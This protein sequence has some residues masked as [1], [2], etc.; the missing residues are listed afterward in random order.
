MMRKIP[1]LIESKN[2]HDTLNV[3][4]NKLQGEVEKQ[5]KDDK[6][7]T[8]EKK[9]CNTEILT[10]NDIPKEEKK[11][12]W[13]NTFGTDKGNNCQMSSLPSKPVSSAKTFAKKFEKVTSATCTQKAKGG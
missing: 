12:D 10:K 3:P 5:L 13:Q 11:P 1:I 2:G 7:V 6:W 4:E 9:D 8:L